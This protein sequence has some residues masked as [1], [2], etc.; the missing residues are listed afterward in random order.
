[1][2]MLWPSFRRKFWEIWYFVHIY[3]SMVMVLG[4]M[5][6]ANQSWYFML[7]GMALQFYERLWRMHKTATLSKVRIVSLKE[8]APGIT[9]LRINADSY[10]PHTPLAA[11]WFISI[12]H[13]AL[14]QWHPFSVSNALNKEYTEFHIQNEG[15][16]TAKLLGLFCLL[17]FESK[18]VP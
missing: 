5:Y 11:Y 7:P 12:P 16:F 4:V 18:M 9:R 6:H 14:L 13:I 1:M 8:V 17:C 2:L 10:H 15:D 3:G